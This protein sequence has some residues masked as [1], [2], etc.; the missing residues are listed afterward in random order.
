M[1]ALFIIITT[2]NNNKNEKYW[3]AIRTIYQCFRKDSGRNV[4]EERICAFK[5]CSEEGAFKKA[6]EEG[7]QY[8]K[9][10]NMVRHPWMVCYWQDGDTLIDGYELWS[11]L[12]ESDNSLSEIVEEKYNKYVYLEK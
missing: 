5:S 8:A 2:M 12:F 3:F 4:F 1:L 10:N 9:D 6:Y 7:V 11:E